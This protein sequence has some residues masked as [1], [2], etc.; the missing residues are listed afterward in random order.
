MD[1]IYN[2]QKAL[3]DIKVVLPECLLLFVGVLPESLSYLIFFGI[4]EQVAEE[5]GSFP[6]TLLS[7]LEA[8]PQKKISSLGVLLQIIIRTLG[9]LPHVIIGSLGVIYFHNLC[10]KI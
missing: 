6:K 5:S 4:P 2:S 9:V 3:N 10:P 7:I 8:L 1:E